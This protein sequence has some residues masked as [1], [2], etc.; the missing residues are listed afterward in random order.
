MFKTIALCGTILI[1]GTAYANDLISLF[2]IENYDQTVDNFIDP[3][4]PDYNQPLLTPTQQQQ[5]MDEFYSHYFSSS[6]NDNSPWN[7]AYVNL[8]YKSAAP[9]DIKSLELSI[10]QWLTNKGKPASK[11][12]YGENFRPHTDAWMDAIQANMNLDQFAGASYQDNRRGI[13]IT[14]LEGRGLPFDDP[15][16]YSYKLPG[17]GYPFDNDQETAVWAGTPVYVAGLSQDGKWAL[18][19]TPDVLTWVHSNAIAYTDDKFINT[20]QTT[21]KA[22]LA[23]ITKTETSIYDQEQHRFRFSAYVGSLFPIKS[24]NGNQLEIMIPTMTKNHKAQINTALVTSD[25]AAMMP[26]APTPHNFANL[27]TTMQGRP[28]GWGSYK[29]YND[30]SAETKSLLTP[31]GIYVMQHS[32]DQLKAGKVVDESAASMQDRINYLS[33]NGHKFM[34][35][36]YIGGHVFLYI[37]NTNRYGFANTPMIYQS[38]WGLSPSDYSRRAVIG[39]TV[40]FPLLTQYPEDPTLVSLANKKYFQVAFL[41]QP[42]KT[43]YKAAPLS[44]VD[45]RE[46]ALPEGMLQEDNPLR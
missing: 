45:L 32:S 38:I 10:V 40:L 36:V 3:T 11:I 30:C 34:N 28:Y 7:P 4:A 23:A 35:I 43:N 24:N 44:A 5:R 22:R 13:T 26:L 31:F 46:I 12:S 21:A 8:Y 25:Q 16:F 19:I 1:A 39:E 18:I 42:N 15:H 9:Y 37:G 27:I 17:Q 6:G 14:N 33:Q 29:F 41:D 20:W 2:P